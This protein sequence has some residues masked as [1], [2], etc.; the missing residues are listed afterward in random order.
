MIG[1]FHVHIQSVRRQLAW[2]LP[3]VWLT[4]LVI[5]VFCAPHDSPDYSV[6]HSTLVS[7]DGHVLHAQQAVT[8]CEDAGNQAR[9]IPVNL[10]IVTSLLWLAFTLPDLLRYF[11]ALGRQ[12]RT[13]INLRWL[14][15]PP[16]HLA[17]CT[18]LN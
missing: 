13:I 11:R 14:H 9:P 2:L 18:F 12:T 5:P 16:V 3:L 4:W 1:R 8:S 6:E 10:F 7:A 15:E 17:K